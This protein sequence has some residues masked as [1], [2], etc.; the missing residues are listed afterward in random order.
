MDVTFSIF[1]PV[2]KTDGL[3][4]HVFTVSAERPLEWFKRNAD[5]LVAKCL[6]GTPYVALGVEPKP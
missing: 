4:M 2:P 5:E 3:V 1:Q 6:P